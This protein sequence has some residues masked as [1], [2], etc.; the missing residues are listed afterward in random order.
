MSAPQPMKLI[1][2]GE[3]KQA[4]T[5]TTGTELFAERRDVVVMR[6]A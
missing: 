1:V 2:D 3:E 4:T 5:G 6:H